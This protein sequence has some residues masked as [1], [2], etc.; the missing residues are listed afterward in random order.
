MTAA[1]YAVLLGYAAIAF[2][3][4]T[5]GYAFDHTNRYPL[6]LMVSAVLAGL[7]SQLFLR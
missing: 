7:L 2:I 4:A 3:W 6:P 5:L 1:I